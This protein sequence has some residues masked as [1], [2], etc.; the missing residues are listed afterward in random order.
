MHVVQTPA[1]PPNQGRMYLPIR[2]WTWKRRKALRAIAAPKARPTA[3]VGGGV[4][5]SVAGELVLVVVG[6]MVA[7]HL[8]GALPCRSVFRCARGGRGWRG[9]SRG[10]CGRPG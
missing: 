1:L 3:R 2:G 5:A 6:V 4:I 7:A 10:R 9:R 8:A